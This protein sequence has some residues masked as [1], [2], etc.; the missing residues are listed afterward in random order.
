MGGG[1]AVVSAG[2]SPTRGIYDCCCCEPELP[3]GRRSACN[4]AG[5]RAWMEMSPRG[6]RRFAQLLAFL[7]QALSFIGQNWQDGRL[8]L[9]CSSRWQGC[10]TLCFLW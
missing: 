6:L 9:C 2:K 7:P 8:P 10:T 3:Y 4:A 1:M 5:S